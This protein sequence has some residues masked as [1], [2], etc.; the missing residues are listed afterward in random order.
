MQDHPKRGLP[1]EF[2][3][4]P[5]DQPVVPRRRAT[6][7]LWV[8]VA[9]FLAT[10]VTTTVVGAFYAGVNPF[11][12][13]LEVWRGLP[14]SLALLVILLSHEM[15]HYLASRR[16][17]VR[18]TL[19]YFIPAPVG[20]GTFG[21][22]IKIKEPIRDRR[23]LLDIG[24][25]GPLAGAVLSIIAVAWGLGHSQVT[26]TSPQEGTLILGEPLLFKALSWIVVGDLPESADVMLHPLAFAG[27][28]GLFV[29]ALNLIPIGQLDGGHIIFALVGPWHVFLS[30]F[31][32]MALVLLGVWG[33]VPYPS[34]TLYLFGALITL[35]ALMIITRAT[36]LRRMT[37]LILVFMWLS[38]LAK[39]SY[40]PGTG[41]WLFWSVLVSF[42]GF[43]HPP[44]YDLHKPLEGWRRVLGLCAI[45]LLVVTFVPRPFRIVS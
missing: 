40:D 27:W 2:E 33:G 29:T 36:K 1:R 6:S 4:Y 11:E 22:F 26:F 12:G 3:E 23:S 21:A 5:F 13:P 44:V 25:A 35:N 24:I 34:M 45:V 43:D 31:A 7:K 16:H 41:V 8:H 28:I 15:G 30:R 10:V 38:M 18:A 17:K 19:P 39:F 42:L 14:F 20:V 32:F 37:F 9:L